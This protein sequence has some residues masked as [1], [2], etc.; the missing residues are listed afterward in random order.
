MAQ[1]PGRAAAGGTKQAPRLPPSRRP[2]RRSLLGAAAAAALWAALTASFRTVTDYLCRLANA[3][4]A[5]A[6]PPLS[7]S[8]PGRCDSAA[9]TPLPRR[10]G[11]GRAAVEKGAVAASA[12]REGP[13]GAAF[14]SEEASGARRQ[15][16][17][18][19]L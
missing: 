8:V 1:R 17:A 3:A 2:H 9:Q 4:A 13:V 5:A 15:V 16:A 11:T 18:R 12:G 6:N 19:L 7:S 14:P 10:C